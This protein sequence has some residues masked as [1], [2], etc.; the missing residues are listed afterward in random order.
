[1]SNKTFGL[2]SKDYIVLFRDSSRSLLGLRLFVFMRSMQGL[3]P[4]PPCEIDNLESMMEHLNT[5]FEQSLKKICLPTG[6]IGIEESSTSSRPK[7][8]SS[9]PKFEPKEFKVIFFPCI[10]FTLKIQGETHH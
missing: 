10:F 3:H 6:H 5:L 4:S 2:I 1:M 9:R 7:F 8:D